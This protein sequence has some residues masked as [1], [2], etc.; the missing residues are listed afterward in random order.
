M[1]CRR[2]VMQAY[3]AVFLDRVLSPSKPSLG[4]YF[5]RSLCG[6]WYRLVDAKM[7]LFMLFTGGLRSFFPL[8]QHAIYSPNLAR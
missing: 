8:H 3:T 4:L 5:C 6:S 1:R 2:K 7:L